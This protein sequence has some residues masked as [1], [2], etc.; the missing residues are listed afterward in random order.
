MKK[1]LVFLLFFLF[2]TP[3]L[4]SISADGQ[5]LKNI[6]VG[7]YDNYPK[8]Y[9]DENGEIKGFW[10][11]ITNYIAEKEDWN[12]T[13]IYD[14]WDNNL[15]NLEN[16]EIDLMVDVAVSEEREQK[17]DFNNETVLI[18]YG[19]FYTRPNI[20]INSFSDLEDKDIAIM[21]SGIHYEGPLGLKNILS[22][23]NI[24][25]NIIDVEIYSD[26]FELLQTNQADV[27]V[28]SWFFGIANEEKY[29]VKRTNLIFNPSEVDY[30]LPK[31]AIRNSYIIGLLDSNLVELK[32]DNN[33]IYHESMRNNF[34][35]LIEEVEVL[36][37]WLNTFM[38][39]VIIAFIL[40]GI[41]FVS[42]RRYQNR[43]KKQIEKEKATAIKEINKYLNVAKI[44][45][46]ALDIKGNITLLNKK[47]YEILEFEEDSL[48]GKNWFDTC[49]PKE[50]I[51]GVKAIFQKCMAGEMKQAEN[52]ENEITDKKGKRRIISW[53]NTLLKDEK[54]KII[55]TLSSGIDIT[56]KK[57]AEKK[58]AELDTL[59]NTFI[60]TV[61]HQLRTPLTAIRWSLEHLLS[62]KNKN[63]LPDQRKLVLSIFE[64]ETEII[65]RI[66]DM[67]E[68][69]D[70]EEERTIINK[71]IF[72][73]DS[74][75]K[76]IITSIK[77]TYSIKQIIL[78]LKIEPKKVY[79]VNADIRKIRTVLEH[80]IDNAVSYTPKKGKIDISL[81]RVN[82]IV[83]VSV[84]DSGIGI[85]SIEQ[86]NI[87]NR[88]FRASNAS[89]IRPDASGLGLT[90]SK[91]YIETHG[92]EIGFSSKEGKGSTF[93]ITLPAAE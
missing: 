25:A 23:F 73:I 29:N 63:L 20:T 18:S 64:Q 6:S 3:F 48:T 22:S 37:R 43:L 54:G 44:I 56:K 89:L 32:E 33:S 57:E 12:I 4:S 36:P 78:T 86:K 52:Y 81:S 51:P 84:K 67:L 35:S 40:A 39:I 28:V 16:G 7:V 30:A 24:N 80:L 79:S 21:K 75:L 19:I 90:I 87:F 47:G 31:N 74:L 42:T 38:T 41:G 62:K 91:Y 34:S 76:S 59:K 2:L 82:N 66:D 58:V 1:T 60:H 83:K 61:S 10:A 72:T 13:Y 50:I 27:G 17:F 88:F 5:D 9:K 53:Y 71:S 55:G 26:V 14:S 92:G 85:P 45:I 69:L 46:V 49:I 70:I 15:T 68:T 77:E 11:D 8:I 93:W 65:K